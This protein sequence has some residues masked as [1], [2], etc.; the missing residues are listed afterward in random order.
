MSRLLTLILC[1]LCFPGPVKSEPNLTQ[2]EGDLAGLLSAVEAGSEQLPGAILRVDAPALGL[3][4]TDAVGTSDLST[5]EPLRPDQTLR[6]ASIT[7]SFIAAAI[8][9]LVED[10][11]FTLDAPVGN[12]L[13]ADTVS[14][15]Q[16]GGYNTQAIKI[17]SLLQHTSG[18]FDFATSDAYLGRVASDPRHRWTRME[19][20]SLA[21]ESGEPYG[22]PGDVY[23]YSDTG[24]VLLGEIIE[25]TTGSAMAEAVNDLLAFDR[26][27]IGDTWFE[28][29][30]PV[31]VGAP[32]RMHQYLESLDANAFDPSLD[33]FGGGGLVSTLEDVSRFYRA[34]H[35][36][37]VFRNEATLGMMLEVSPQS[38]EADARGYGLGIVR[39]EFDGVVCYGHGG[40]WGILAWHCPAI[41]LTVAGA[42]TN[43]MARGAVE[44]M[45]DE[46]IRI[47]A[48][49]IVASRQ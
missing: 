42:A 41:D 10:G 17:W 21:M 43:V 23:R 46:A 1:G 48:A 18:L 33:L 4:W 11:H 14:V 47:A 7:K 16:K 36:G 38:V 13:R 20:V 15:L 37:E 44:T 22:E 28:T 32:S 29:L 25:V 24:Y 34:L 49:A 9:R 19:Q 2:L 5:G 40:F 35:Q 3:I 8:L 45:V 31:P 30:E 26:L 12:H 27:G 39:A 6:I